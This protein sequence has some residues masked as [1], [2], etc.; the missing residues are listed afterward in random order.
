MS[1]I[2]LVNVAIVL[3]ALVYLVITAPK[4]VRG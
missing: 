3:I 4:S 1:V 2:L